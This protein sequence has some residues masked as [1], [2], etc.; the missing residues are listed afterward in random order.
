MRALALMEARLYLRDP[1]A[2]PF[3]LALPLVL[4]LVFGLPE[5]SSRPSED[6]GG[7]VPLDTVLPSLVLS[8]S[9]AMLGAY[10]L[11]AFLTEYRVRGVLRR[12]STTPLSPAAVL[13]AHLAIN[14]AVA[15]AAVLLTLLIGGAALGMAMPE[16]VPGL[17]LVLVLGASSLFSLGLLIAAVARDAPAAYVL[18][19]LFF[20]PSLFFAGVWLPKE[21][22]S[23][24]LSR[25][26]DFTPLGAFRESLEA[27]W[28][29]S[30]PEPLALGV[31]AVLTLAAGGAAARI[32][33][34]E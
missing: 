33:R 7:Q 30:A 21:Q 13:V 23:P 6:F 14:L 4:L 2:L 3:A 10:M 20:F 19:A 11:P 9:F 25:I 16:N 15:V 17:V 8:L 18:G 1:M 24:T 34:W 27:A 5:D 28:T 29:G 26:G 22:M 32:F 12:L 31:M